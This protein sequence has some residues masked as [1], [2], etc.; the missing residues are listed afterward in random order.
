MSDQSS[1]QRD[2]QR[3]DQ[4]QRHTDSPVGA[5]QNALARRLRALHIP[6]EPLILVNVR[7]VAGTRAADQLL[8]RGDY[9]TDQAFPMPA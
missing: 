9:L 2:D 3:D 1:D 5:D 4:P 6:G 8:A 7:D